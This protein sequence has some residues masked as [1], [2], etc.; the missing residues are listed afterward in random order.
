MCNNAPGVSY[1]VVVLL[2]ALVAQTEERVALLLTIPGVGHITA[3]A[4]VATVRI[5]KQINNGCELAAWF[6]LTPLNRSS[7]GRERLGSI[8]KMGYQYTRRLL[9]IGMMS[10]MRQDYPKPRMV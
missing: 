7:G 10:R 2:T 9:V 5:G 8:S 3:S 4:I 1:S 6:G